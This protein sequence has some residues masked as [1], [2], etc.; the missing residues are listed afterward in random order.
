MHVAL[1]KIRRLSLL[2]YV[3]VWVRQL[4]FFFRELDLKAFGILKCELVSRAVLDS[5]MNTE[6]C[7][8]FFLSSLYQQLHK[9]SDLFDST[10]NSTFPFFSYFAK[11]TTILQ[12]Q[13]PQLEFL[14]DDLSR[15]LQYSLSASASS[16]RS[17]LKVSISIVSTRDLWW[18][19]ANTNL[20]CIYMQFK[21]VNN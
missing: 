12:L 9:Q 1:H 3:Y 8:E 18:K 11:E 5:E 15:K 19:S 16:R 21:G 6:V 20:K 4:V 7:S 17:F 10:L 14:L 2:N 13:A